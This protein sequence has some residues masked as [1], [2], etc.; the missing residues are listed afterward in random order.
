MF[1]AKRELYPSTQMMGVVAGLSE[2]NT[3][4]PLAEIAI[5]KIVH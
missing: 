5:E 1:L 3:A 2:Q 4:G